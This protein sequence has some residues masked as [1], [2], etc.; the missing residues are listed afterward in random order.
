MPDHPSA[1]SVKVSI[2]AEDPKKPSSRPFKF[3]NPNEMSLADIYNHNRKPE[4]KDHIAAIKELRDF[5]DQHQDTIN[6]LQLRKD[7]LPEGA[8]LIPEQKQ[9]LDR[10]EGWMKEKKTWLRC[11]CWSGTFDT[12]KEAPKNNTLVQHSGRLQIDIDWEGKPRIQSE[13]LRDK[14]GKDPHIEASLLSPRGRGVKCGMLIPIC[15]NDAEH[16]QAYFAAERY[17]KE[18]Y[19][20]RIDP[21]CKDVRRICFFS[22]DP[23]LITNFNAVPLNIKK[24]SPDTKQ[25]SESPSAES[26]RTSNPKSPKARQPPTLEYDEPTEEQWDE[27]FNHIK[28]PGDRDVWIEVGLA[29]K[30]HFGNDGYERWAD[31][32]SNSYKWDDVEESE[33]RER[34]DKFNPTSTKGIAKLIAK[35]KE[36]GWKWK[37][38]KQEQQGRTK[39]KTSAV[40]DHPAQEEK[41]TSTET[42]T[43]ATE[44]DSAEE[45]T[46]STE[47]TGSVTKTANYHYKKVGRGKDEKLLVD[48]TLHNVYEAFT[49]NKPPIWFDSFLRQYRTTAYQDDEIDVEMND[50]IITEITLDFQK[51]F[52]G[53][54]RRLSDKLVQKAVELYGSKDER[55]CLTNWL[56]SLQ[57]DKTPRLDHWLSSYCGAEDNIYVREVARCWLLGAVSRAYSPGCKFD[58]CLVMEGEQGI[59]KST[60][61]EILSDCIII[62]NLR[63]DGLCKKTIVQKD[64]IKLEF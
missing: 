47:A 14:L 35:A 13:Q 25:T 48:S 3:G 54:M 26:T 2:G 57:W 63:E 12:S 43:E 5:V 58:F 29:T 50:N 62:L 32:S 45:T 6:E 41:E 27:I 19:E 30:Q 10:L 52:E 31:W 51:S 20:I 46:P 60:A 9:E 53:P 23:D 64:S 24:W 61:L 44:K 7:K 34:W 37:K 40:A 15:T 16:K 59:G 18:T 1:T 56:N 38:N 36:G 21:A 42:K 4:S 17:F 28:N 55:N 22:H 49:S 39:K 33:H 11:F 8:T